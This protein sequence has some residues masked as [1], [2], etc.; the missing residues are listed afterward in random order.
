MTQYKGVL[1]DENKLRICKRLKQK[2]Y[3]CIYKVYRSISI[4]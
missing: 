2:V 1:C 4:H 3:T